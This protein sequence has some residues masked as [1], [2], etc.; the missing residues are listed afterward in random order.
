MGEHHI[1]KA[2]RDENNKKGSKKGKGGVEVDIKEFIKRN[3]T[4]DTG[5]SAIFP[6]PGGINA[7]NIIF[8]VG[9]NY[10]KAKPQSDDE[11]ESPRGEEVEKRW[12]SEEDNL[13]YDTY[14]S[15]MITAKQEGIESLGISLVCAGLFSGKRGNLDAILNIAVQAVR[16]NVYAELDEVY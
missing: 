7:A 11:K 8:T 15:C 6:C 1:R 4:L 12:T 5:M 2:A 14:Q 9:P 16:E 10:A 3:T 13:L